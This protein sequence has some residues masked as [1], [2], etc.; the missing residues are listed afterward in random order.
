MWKSLTLLLLEE[1]SGDLLSGGRSYRRCYSSIN[2]DLRSN[3]N[4]QLCVFCLETNLHTNT[5]SEKY[6][7][8]LG[9][10]NFLEKIL[11]WLKLGLK[12]KGRISTSLFA[13]IFQTNIVTVFFFMW[14]NCLKYKNFQP[15][16]IC[17]SS[18]MCHSNI[19][20]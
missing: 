18:E 5:K 11:F 3:I 19:F 20:W 16:N 6:S 10:W 13:L 8:F 15:L 12:I 1:F 17:I 4:T 9:P 14:G 2:P 7:R